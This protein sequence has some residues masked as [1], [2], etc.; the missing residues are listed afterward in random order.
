[1]TATANETLMRPRWQ[2]SPAQAPTP[3]ASPL[4][5]LLPTAEVATVVSG[6]PRAR[7]VVSSG[8]TVELVWALPYTTHLRPGDA[9][10]VLRA[11]A[12][13][14]VIGVLRSAR[15]FT[16]LLNEAA[17][18]RGFRLR[19]RGDLGVKLMAPDLRIRAR[20]LVSEAVE[21]SER[22]QNVARRVLG[23]LSVRAR[24]ARTIVSGEH[25]TRAKRRRGVG[26]E[27]HRLDGGLVQFGQ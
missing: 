5:P 24:S 21:V 25:H 16:L 27:S 4:S 10:Q 8:E 14:Y 3:E 23:K 6:G 11:G 2:S 18:L 17:Q 19:L 15:G 12:S 20:K 7:A 13:C 1:M 22:F 9:V 26:A